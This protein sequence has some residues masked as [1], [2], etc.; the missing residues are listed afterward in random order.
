MTH[1]D[2][3]TRQLTLTETER[4]FM[5]V[6][7][8]SS[9][10]AVQHSVPHTLSI[11]G[12]SA[13]KKDEK[14]GDNKA[15]VGGLVSMD[16]NTEYSIISLH[17]GTAIG[18]IIAIVIM[19]AIYYLVFNIRCSHTSTIPNIN[20]IDRGHKMIK[21]E[22]MIEYWAPCFINM[23]EDKENTKKTRWIS[24]DQLDSLFK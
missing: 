6:D 5:T 20:N 18:I 8:E 15:S 22:P 12:S 13:S 1:L 2:D 24:R 9:K 14:I 17:T 21:R 3:K 7:R 19:S 16:M 23:P 11:M 10:K 4:D